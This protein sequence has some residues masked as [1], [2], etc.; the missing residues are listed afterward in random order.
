VA[1]IP[2]R[3]LCAILARQPNDHLVDG[4]AALRAIMQDIETEPV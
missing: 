3:R 1:A 4:V 2:Y